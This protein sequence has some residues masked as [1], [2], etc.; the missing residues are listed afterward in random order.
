LLRGGGKFLLSN[1]KFRLRCR[2][3]LRGNF[4]FLPGSLKFLPGGGLGLGG[5]KILLVFGKKVLPNNVERANF[6]QPRSG[7][8]ANPAVSLIVSAGVRAVDF[9]RLARGT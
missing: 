8:K 7:R 3:F 2:K 9:G 5:G 1:G 6:Y 4:S